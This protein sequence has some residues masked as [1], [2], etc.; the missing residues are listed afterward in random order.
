MHSQLVQSSRTAGS[1]VREGDREKL[2]SAIR[3]IAANGGEHH[4]MSEADLGTLKARE[5]PRVQQ[6]NDNQA[7]NNGRSRQLDAQR[8][9]GYGR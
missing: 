3:S 2:A 1:A 6:T 7:A 8:S 4:K 9:L 5:T